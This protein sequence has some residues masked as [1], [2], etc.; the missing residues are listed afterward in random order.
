MSKSLIILVVAVSAASVL[1]LTASSA[2]TGGSFT[3]DSR[4]DAKSATNVDAKPRGESAGDLNV[5]STSLTRDGHPAGR[6]E[7]VQ[8][9]VDSHY[10]G[11]SNRVDLLLSDGTLELQG[12]GLEKRPPGGAKPAPE[13]DLAIIGGTGAYAGARGAVRVTDTSR[14][15]QRL[16][17]TLAG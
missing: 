3:I 2:A 7:Y 16:T 14:T 8:T 1:P 10:R 13:T 5:F 11:I 17:V 15:T 4:L 12:A 9:L 6:A